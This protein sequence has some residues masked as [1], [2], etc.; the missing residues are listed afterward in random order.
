MLKR[1]NEKIS[2]VE[3][4]VLCG[5]GFDFSRWQSPCIEI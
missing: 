3:P 5:K 2:S 4:C 1:N